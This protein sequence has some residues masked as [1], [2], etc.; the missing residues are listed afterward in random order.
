MTFVSLGVMVL[1]TIR[2]HIERQKEEDQHKS[3]ELSQTQNSGL[4]WSQA[5][6]NELVWQRNSTTQ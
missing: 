1:L 5:A 2:R 6:R 3:V 4:R